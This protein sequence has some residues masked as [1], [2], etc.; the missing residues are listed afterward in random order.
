MKNKFSIRIVLRTDKRRQNG[1]FP[2]YYIVNLNGK[3]FKLSTGK[4]IAKSDW[5]FKAREPKASCNNLRRILRRE[6]A[7]LEDF[8]DKRLARNETV[9]SEMIKRFYKGVDDKDFF[10]YY[11]RFLALK[12]KT[13]KE[14]TVKSYI[15]TL[16]HLKKFRGSVLINE[17]DLNFVTDF[18]Y[19]LRVKCNM[20]NGGAWSRHKN[21]KTVINKLVNEGLLENT[22]YGNGKFEVKKPE[23]NTVY[24]D[25]EEIKKLVELRSKLSLKMRVNI[26]RFLFSCFTGFRYSDMVTLKW[27]DIKSDGTITKRMVKT[28][29][30]VVVP[31]TEK[32]A[33]ILERY[34]GKR[35]DLIFPKISNNKI[36]KALRTICKLAR[37]DK[38][39][40]FHVARHTFGYILGKNS[41][42]AFKIMHLMGHS[43]VKQTMRYVNAPVSDLSLALNGI[44]LFKKVN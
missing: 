6:V 4:W 20:A 41:L 26:D 22:P 17:I 10:A 2:I 12:R 19:Y 5:D 37:I 32:V 1:E 44:D 21:L 14:S 15:G 39:V 38:K 7:S 16:N 31:V 42:N 27:S 3:E 11:E 35:N 33:E 13:E 24:L 34:E 29:K 43:S 28:N 23:T 18:D 8:H 40:T 30:D 36:N 25:E 9:T